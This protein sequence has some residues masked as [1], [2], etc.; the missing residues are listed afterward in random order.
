MSGQECHKDSTWPLLAGRMTGTAKAA[1]GRAALRCWRTP[2]SLVCLPGP[3][4][5]SE[6]HVG[7]IF[8]R[9]ALCD[10]NL[11]VPAD[12]SYANVNQEVAKVK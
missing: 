6:L 3:G 5:D 4:F 8:F 7:R 12:C 10:F 9:A 2:G 1:L 11:L